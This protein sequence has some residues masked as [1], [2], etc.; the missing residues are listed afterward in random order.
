M[1]NRYNILNLLGNNSKKYHSCIITSYSFDFLFFEQRVLPILRNAGIININIF[2]DA[3]MLQ[4]KLSDSIGLNVSNKKSYSIIPIDLKGA[5]HPKIIMAIGK[6][7]G[8]I[9]VGSG[10]L[11]SSGLSTNDEIWSAFHTKEHQK[12]NSSIFKH[13]QNYVQQLEEKAFGFT[14]EKLNWISTNSEWYK[15]LKQEK[16]E[17]NN[18][19][20]NKNEQVE[21]FSSFVNSSIYKQ[22][23]DKLPTNPNCIKILSPFY[24]KNGSFLTQL[25]DDLKPKK[26]H[27]IVDPNY[28]TLPFKFKSEYIEYSNWNLLEKD[29]KYAKTRLHAKAFQFEYKDKTFFLF[30]SANATTEAFGTKNSSSKNAEIVTL[31]QSN[32]AKDYFEELLIKFPKKGTYTFDTY[33]YL[34]LTSN[35]NYSNHNIKIYYTEINNYEITLYTSLNEVKRREILI[36]NT[37]DEI[38]QEFK[39]VEIK[40]SCTFL[41][42]NNIADKAFKVVIYYNNKADSNFSKVHF[43]EFL[44]R[45]NPNEALAKL[46][47]L[48]NSDVFGDLELEE[49]LEYIQFD[50]PTNKNITN[51]SSIIK[52][53]EAKEDEQEEVEAVTTDEFNKNSSRIGVLKSKHWHQMELLEDFLNNLSFG[54]EKTEDHSDSSEQTAL[55]NIESGSSQ[56]E[57]VKDKLIE[58]KFKQGISLKNKLHKKISQIE[59]YLKNHKSEYSNALYRNETYTEFA[60]IDKI[61][62]LL[63]GFHLILIQKE[64]TF[65]EY[66]YTFVLSNTNS[67]VFGRLKDKYNLSYLSG[68]ANS[69]ETKYSIAEDYLFEF[70]KDI[71]KNKGLKISRIDSTP[72]INII[73]HF[74]KIIQWSKKDN[75]GVLETFLL[76]ALGSFL[77]L[78][79]KNEHKYKDDIDIKK[80]SMY[81]ERLFYKVISILQY[82]NWSESDNYKLLLL[83]S[84]NLLEENLTPD[85]FKLKLL[86]L[87]EKIKNTVQFNVISIEKIIILYANYYNWKTICKKD[88]QNYK[89]ELDKTIINKVIYS[90]KVGFAVLKKINNDKTITISTPLGINLKKKNITGFENLFIGTKP[91]VFNI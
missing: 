31:I 63:I 62:S 13:L 1:I 48:L 23:L 12:S 72:S 4:Q 78:S 46:N 50:K 67:K 38:L 32:V 45:T 65:S 69:A 91:L 54:E 33:E 16:T 86:E 71:E 19:K 11:T 77:L 90:K 17:T 14:K 28:G 57:T 89:K 7:N 60:D 51:N 83:N 56:I 34:S 82:Y 18:E 66:K 37:D 58:L 5:F 39:N 79:L 75:Y 88:I 25:I 74:F 81:K 8:F 47:K 61:K 10:N 40:N 27:A 68:N 24:N 30:G 55:E 44:K 70:K 29:S 87:Q 9:A 36:L 49:I 42:E 76:N 21:I 26:I 41:L 64:K 53:K 80:W 43:Q 85:K 6:K 84:F 2:V 73:H 52:I 3:S 15:D 22:L 20:L 35:I 59:E